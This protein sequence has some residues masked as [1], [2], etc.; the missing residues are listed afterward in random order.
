MSKLQEQLDAAKDKLE[1]TT[2]TA[3]QETAVH[4]SVDA[5]T[6]KADAAL[7]AKAGSGEVTLG[8]IANDEY[9][10]SG[11]ST[12]HSSI[13]DATKESIF[14]VTKS[15]LDSLVSYTPVQG[16][17]EEIRLHSFILPNGVKVEPN[18]QGFY[19]GKELTAEGITML[20]YYAK[21]GLVVKFDK[22]A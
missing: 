10:G 21:K 1:G 22:V 7:I 19:V 20:D 2:T 3:K 16:D 8:A 4:S 15:S 13:F 11:E 17:Y 9:L 14:D 6:A 5:D 12:I 18:I